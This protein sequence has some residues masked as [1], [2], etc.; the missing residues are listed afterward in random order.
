[1]AWFLLLFAGVLEMVWPIATKYSNGNH[2]TLPLLVAVTAMIANVFLLGAAMRTLPVG[3]VY[4]V[5]IGF[6]AIGTC[7]ASV[8]LF[9][10]PLGFHRALS[11][12]LIVA[13]VFGLK[14][15]AIP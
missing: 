15:S 5:L 13:G 14:S 3:T 11:L 12:A 7:L 8:I 6:G 4:G 1:M 10:E 9:K 2:R